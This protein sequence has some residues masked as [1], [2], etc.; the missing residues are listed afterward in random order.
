[1]IYFDFVENEHTLKLTHCLTKKNLIL[2]LL[3]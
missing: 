3:I 1:M 2:V